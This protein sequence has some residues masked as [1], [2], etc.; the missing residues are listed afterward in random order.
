MQGQRAQRLKAQAS[1]LLLRAQ[2]LSDMP[3]CVPALPGQILATL[4]PVRAQPSGTLPPSR[5]PCPPACSAAAQAR[6]G[7]GPAPARKSVLSSVN[8]PALAISVFMMS[9]IAGAP[10]DGPG[11]AA[12]AS[13]A[14]A[15]AA[16]AA[17]GAPAAAGARRMFMN[18]AYTGVLPGDGEGAWGMAAMLPPSG[19]GAA[20][21][22]IGA[23]AG[24][25]APLRAPANGA[26]ALAA[27]ASADG[28]GLPAASA[29]MA[30]AGALAMAPLAA[31]AALSRAAADGAGAGAP[32]GAMAS[33]AP[34]PA[35]GRG[36]GTVA[37]GA[38]AAGAGAGAT[39]ARPGAGLPPAPADTAGAG[40]PAA[41]APA[42]GTGLPPAYESGA[43]AGARSAGRPATGAGPGE[44]AA[45]A[46]SALAGARTPG[47]SLDGAPACRSSRA[48][49]TKGAER[50]RELGSRLQ[51]CAALG[52][53]M[54]QSAGS[55]G[56]A[57]HLGCRTA[58][59]RARSQQPAPA[60]RR[61]L[62][63]WCTCCVCR[64][65]T[66]YPAEMYSAKT[67]SASYILCDWGVTLVDGLRRHLGCESR[68]LDAVGITLSANNPPGAQFCLPALGRA[69]GPP[70]AV[71]RIGRSQLPHHFELGVTP[72]NTAPSPTNPCSTQSSPMHASD[73]QAAYILQ[74]AHSNA[75]HP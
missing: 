58:G 13:S 34:V 8:A 1:C 19:P 14:G 36:A 4:R 47:P 54:R 39:V 60:K 71:R 35:D 67:R 25:I 46:A 52:R 75:P 37:A 51:A 7:E 9:A 17:A 28:A 64:P 23:G 53:S 29:G 6:A 20:A 49:G 61:G 5:P 15:G 24:T 73:V 65:V 57:A 50:P 42:A 70:T 32:T 68:V 44:P 56:R 31:G 45:P 16:T 2:R 22:C 72:P 43:G 48:P 66:I 62:E 30:G 38:S 55:C 69:D 33:P 74:L 10:A 26:G 40:A 3:A 12:A 59:R 18:A 41:G 63:A 11:A 21:S 27:G